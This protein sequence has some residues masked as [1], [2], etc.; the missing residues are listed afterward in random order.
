M[1]SYLCEAA[2]CG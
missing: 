2:G 1:S